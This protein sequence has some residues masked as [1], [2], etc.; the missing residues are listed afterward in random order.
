MT[1]SKST[2]MHQF[3]LKDRQQ[4]I[5]RPALRGRCSDR[6]FGIRIITFIFRTPTVFSQETRSTIS[7]II[8]D[9]RWAKLQS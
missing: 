3:S 2:V 5:Y 6:K 1:F 7:E 4:R 8:I 9:L